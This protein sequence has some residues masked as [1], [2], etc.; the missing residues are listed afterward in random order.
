[1]IKSEIALKVDA[2]GGCP[3]A[4]L[5]STPTHLSYSHLPFAF[6]R[7]N[8]IPIPFYSLEI[9]TQGKTHSLKPITY[10]PPTVRSPSKHSP[11]CLT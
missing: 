1:M 3:D 9:S 10:P 11:S 7:F 6:P 5:L 8:N 2:S 4:L